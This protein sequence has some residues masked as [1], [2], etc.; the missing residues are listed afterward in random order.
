VY[1]GGKI[2]MEINEKK[3]SLLK[4]WLLDFPNKEYFKS[5]VKM[6]EFI[7]EYELYRIVEDYSDGAK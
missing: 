5:K 4:K 6:R 1:G 3:V 7:N 2:K